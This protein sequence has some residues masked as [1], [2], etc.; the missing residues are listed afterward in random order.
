MEDEMVLRCFGCLF[1]FLAAFA[2]FAFLL[3]L[4]TSNDD[5]TF[6]VFTQF[7]DQW[8]CILKTIRCAVGEATPSAGGSLASASSAP[9]HVLQS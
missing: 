4:K 8:H 9:G 6:A 3:R 5:T 2:P 7:L 1:F